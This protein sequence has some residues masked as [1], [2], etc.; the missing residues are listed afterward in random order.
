MQSIDQTFTLLFPCK[1]V[2]KNVLIIFEDLQP[3]IQKT[4]GFTPHSEYTCVD[5]PEWKNA[6]K[7]CLSSAMLIILPSVADSRVSFR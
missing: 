1:H 7:D 2:L 4:A 3:G 6:V 5:L